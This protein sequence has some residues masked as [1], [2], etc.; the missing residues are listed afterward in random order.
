MVDISFRLKERALLVFSDPQILFSCLL[1]VFIGILS[2]E[3]VFLMDNF[4]DLLSLLLKTESSFSNAFLFPLPAVK[5]M[6]PWEVRQCFLKS[7]HFLLVKEQ[8][9]HLKIPPK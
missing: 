6:Y 8:C 3:I 2:N 7:S 1:M 4:V 5:L 9:L